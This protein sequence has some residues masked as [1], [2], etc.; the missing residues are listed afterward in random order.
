MSKNF[1]RASK[2][3][4]IEESA[5]VKL[6]LVKHNETI[7]H[8]PEKPLTRTDT[9]EYKILTTGIPVRIPPCRIAPGR[10]KILDE[11]LKM[12]KEVN[13]QKSSGPWCSPI[14]LVRKK[15]GML[16]YCVDHAL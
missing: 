6:Y 14:V 5:K 13:I 4:S 11:I 9:I 3:L 1:I 2:N 10:R 8:D 12:E 15:D 16:Y 7:F